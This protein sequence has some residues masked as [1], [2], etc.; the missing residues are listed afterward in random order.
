MINN[1]IE[2]IFSHFKEAYPREGCGV[3][4]VVKGKSRWF[5]CGNIAEEDDD[6]VMD[7]TDYIN[8]SLRSDI[9]AVVHSH[10]D[11]DPEPSEADIKACN[12]LNLD[13]YIFSWPAG[14]MYHLEPD[15]EKVPLLGREYE[16]GVFD[17]WKLVIDYYEVELGIK[18][19]RDVYEDNWWKHGLN[20]MDDLYEEYGFEQVT[21]GSLIKN[22][23]MFFNIKSNIPNHCGVYLGDDMLLHHSEDRLSCRERLHGSAWGRKKYKILRHKECKQ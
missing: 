11:Q 4:G 1:H 2:D 8:A 7:S 19:K 5:P 9:V 22:D 14:E 21:D 23:L 16:F 3:I 20:Y 15:R 6:F 18:L 13:Y 12:T 17:C 10:P